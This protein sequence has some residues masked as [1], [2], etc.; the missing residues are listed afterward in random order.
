[1]IEENKR[2]KEQIKKLKRE[3][4][5][6]TEIIQSVSPALMKF[7][8]REDHLQFALGQMKERTACPVA[9]KDLWILMDNLT[10][11]RVEDLLRPRNEV[12]SE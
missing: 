12:K 3:N 11:N 9:K 5:T 1:M 7:K 2:L 8:K 4:Q 6:K 10:N